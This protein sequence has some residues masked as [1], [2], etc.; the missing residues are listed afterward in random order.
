MQF[1]L[2][3]SVVQS[4]LHNF[5]FPGSYGYLFKLSP[6]K[7]EASYLRNGFTN[8]NEIGLIRKR[9]A[10]AI[11]RS[12]SSWPQLRPLTRYQRWVSVF[13]AYLLGAPDLQ[14]KIVIFGLRSIL[15]SFWCIFRKTV[16]RF[17]NLWSDEFVDS[18]HFC[19]FSE[20]INRVAAVYSEISCGVGRFAYFSFFAELRVFDA[21]NFED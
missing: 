7:F 20:S 6:P 10:G 1:I 9:I 8:F 12:Y 13:A 15:R 14:K 4:I 21:F 19:N 17:W 16:V 18:Y 5:H 2:R 3:F 11:K